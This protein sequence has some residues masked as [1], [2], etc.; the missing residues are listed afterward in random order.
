MV[1]RFYADSSGRFEFAMLWFSSLLVLKVFSTW[2]DIAKTDTSALITFLVALVSV[3]VLAGAAIRRARD[4]GHSGW[5]AFT[6]LVPFVGL[7]FLFA[8]GKNA[9]TLY[10]KVNSGI[11]D[12]KK[13]E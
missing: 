3:A 8:P 1:K 5:W 2:A 13:A 11:F 7:Y 10:E 12:N 4:L 6:I 9:P